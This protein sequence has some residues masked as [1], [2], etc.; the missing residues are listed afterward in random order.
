MSTSQRVKTILESP[1]FGKILPGM[2]TSLFKWNI[3]HDKKL[4]VSYESTQHPIRIPLMETISLM[5]NQAEM[6]NLFTLNL[7]E[8]ENFLRDKNDTPAFLEADIAELYDHLVSQLITVFFDYHQKFCLSTRS[9]AEENHF[10]MD[11]FESLDGVDFVIK[12][13]S[14]LYFFNK[15]SDSIVSFTFSE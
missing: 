13:K 11:L 14:A 15:R 4:T 9:F 10:W 12:E 2:D 6:S 7:R 5:L 3:S 8:I 1:Q